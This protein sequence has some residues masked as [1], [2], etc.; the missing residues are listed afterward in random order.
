MGTQEKILK[1]RIRRGEI[2]KAVLQTISA[3]G[4]LS[5][6]LLAPNALQMIKLFDGGK[7]KNLRQAINTSRRRLVANGLLQYKNGFLR[8]TKKGELKLEGLERRDYRLPIPSKWDK[9]WRVLIFDIPEYRRL[10]RD[11]VRLTLS[12]IGFK[13]LQQSVWVYPYDCED[14]ITL[15]KADFKIGKDMLYLIV[16]SIENDRELKSFFDLKS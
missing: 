15:I 4:I 13:R 14:L 1:T 6:A 7:R 9:K 8:L 12:S 11:K 16:D 2:Q 10:V 5:I 3:V